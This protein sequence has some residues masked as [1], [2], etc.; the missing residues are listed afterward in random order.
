MADYDIGF[1]IPKMRKRILTIGMLLFVLTVINIGPSIT[2]QKTSQIIPAAAPL[3]DL[4]I[5]FE[6]TGDPGTYNFIVT[7]VGDGDTNP[8]SYPPLLV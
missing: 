8:P 2:A 6:T 7:N 5:E 4:I 3:P 1:R